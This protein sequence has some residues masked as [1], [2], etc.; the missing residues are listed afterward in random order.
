MNLLLEEFWKVN[1]ARKTQRHKFSIDDMIGVG[2]RV[3]VGSLSDLSDPVI[4]LTISASELSASWPDFSKASKNVKQR[5]LTLRRE[6]E[7]K[8]SLERRE[9]ERAS[10]PPCSSSPPSPSYPADSGGSSPSPS[11]RQFSSR[12]SCNPL[13]EE[14]KRQI[15]EKEKVLVTRVLQEIGKETLTKLFSHG[16]ANQ[17]P[18][19][20]GFEEQE[21]VWEE[22]RRKEYA[23]GWIRNYSI[24][25]KRDNPLFWYNGLQ[26][27]DLPPDSI[28]SKNQNYFVTMMQTVIQTGKCTEFAKAV[29][30]IFQKAK[31]LIASSP[32]INMV[33]QDRIGFRS[34]GVHDYEIVE[35]YVHRNASCDSCS[36]E[37]SE[38]R[39]RNS[40]IEREIESETTSH[41]S[42]F[43]DKFRKDH[44][45]L[46]VQRVYVHP[47]GEKENIFSLTVDFWPMSQHQ[48]AMQGDLPIVDSPENHFV[49][50]PYSTAGA[51]ST[52]PEADLEQQLQL[53]QEGH[54]LLQRILQG[55]LP[56]FDK[57]RWQGSMF[58]KNMIGDMVGLSSEMNQTILDRDKDCP[59]FQMD[60]G[61][62][63][64]K[65]EKTFSTLSTTFFPSTSSPLVR[66]RTPGS[67]F[68]SSSPEKN[69]FVNPS[70]FWELQV[71]W[72]YMAKTYGLLGVHAMHY[73]ALQATL[74][75]SASAVGIGEQEK[76]E[77]EV[78]LYEF[79][80]VK[81][82]QWADI[83]GPFDTFSEMDKDTIFNRLL[84]DSKKCAEQREEQIKLRQGNLENPYLGSWSRPSR[85]APEETPVIQA[86]R[87]ANETLKKQKQEQQAAAAA[88]EASTSIASPHLGVPSSL[89]LAVPV[90]RSP[91]ATE[92]DSTNTSCR[93][94]TDLVDIPP[95][96]SSYVDRELRKCVVPEHLHRQNGITYD[97]YTGV[98]PLLVPAHEKN[99]GK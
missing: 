10:P 75:T 59:T 38:Q 62:F 68:L 20:A 23:A 91:S 30:H 43:F 63:L 21:A 78:R 2:G 46:E 49:G 83:Y 25:W 3:G 77:K 47:N 32:E 81:V 69:S 5:A 24:L 74:P 45:W 86:L 84:P 34:G 72:E 6:E 26:D 39:D 44:F 52:H 90:S 36:D 95:R 22:A 73:Q 16:P 53:S 88:A 8:K 11:S 80:Q 15:I 92:T 17:I 42:L 31:V 96:W 93:Y 87:R 50:R 85:Y 67:P 4:G 33:E 37:T 40:G 51:T 19:A 54:V 66:R 1:P 70:D 60:F 94:I 55:S 18:G 7:E 14:E 64:Q 57:M 12:S 61:E 58:L 56:D 99:E 48:L 79:L 41:Q 29:E 65:Y 89:H 98:T 97:W 13:S 27:L 9:R 71:V 76:E 28:L 82:A 35:K